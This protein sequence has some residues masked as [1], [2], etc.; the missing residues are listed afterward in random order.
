MGNSR[1]SY[2]NTTGLKALPFGNR[3]Q[4]SLAGKL[5]E[6]NVHAAKLAVLLPQ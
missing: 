5:S 4:L 1:D 3:L 2:K 6:A